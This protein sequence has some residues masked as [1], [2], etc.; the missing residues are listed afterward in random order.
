MYA[1]IQKPRMNRPLYEALSFLLRLNSSYEEGK[2]Y[3]AV[4]GLA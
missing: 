1:S 4:A 3:A 2:V